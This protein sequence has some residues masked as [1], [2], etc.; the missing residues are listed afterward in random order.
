MSSLLL[1][2]KVVKRVKD[3][4]N[5]DPSLDE[6]LEQY[7]KAQAKIDRLEQVIARKHQ[8]LQSIVIRN[9]S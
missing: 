6:A 1:I 9:K 2:D 4:A 5:V 7:E 8:R 3:V